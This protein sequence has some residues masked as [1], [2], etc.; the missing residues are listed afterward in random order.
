M[1]FLKLC[2]EYKVNVFLVGMVQW[3][4]GDSGNHELKS[5]CLV[6][7]HLFSIGP[8]KIVAEAL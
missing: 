2:N 6:L 5:D 8:S 3:L 7:I 1:T 4:I